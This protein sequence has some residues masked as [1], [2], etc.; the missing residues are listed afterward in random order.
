MCGMRLSFKSFLK[1]DQIPK[2]FWTA[3][4]QTTLRLPKI[5]VS[6]FV[7]GLIVF[8]VGQ[9]LLYGTNL[10]ASPRVVF[11]QGLALFFR[12]QR[13]H[14]DFSCWTLRFIFIG[15]TQRKARFSNNCSPINSSSSNWGNVAK[16][17]LFRRTMAAFANFTPEYSPDRN[18]ISHM[19]GGKTW[20]RPK[21]WTYDRRSRATG[22]PIAVVRNSIELFVL[23]WD[24]IW[25]K[26]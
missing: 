17:L 23:F 15:A 14:F 10:G 19:F 11:S 9:A 4:T 21:K 6:F 20:T 24:V 22:L 7:F 2:L 16:C 18:C 8:N 12:L 5:F 26:L 25:E 1:I 13:W 3:P